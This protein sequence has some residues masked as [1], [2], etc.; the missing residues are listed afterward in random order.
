MTPLIPSATPAKHGGY[1]LALVCGPV[2]AWLTLQIGLG[3]RATA[4]TPS[5]LLTLLVLAPVAE[6]TV[7][8]LGLHDWLLSKFQAQIG[9]VSLA[10]VLVAL[11]FG[12]VHALNHGSGLMLLSAVPALVFGWL[13]EASARRLIMPVSAHAWYNLCIVLASC[14]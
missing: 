5:A 4:C 11:I 6:E 7:F 8:R 10:N 1:A 13:W 2:G 14:Q 12:T 3:L 9:P